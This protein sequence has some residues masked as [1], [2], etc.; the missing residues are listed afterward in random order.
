MNGPE[1][2]MAPD[3]LAML[4]QSDEALGVLETNYA[5]DT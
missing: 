5:K 4:W 2:G 1:V 3:D